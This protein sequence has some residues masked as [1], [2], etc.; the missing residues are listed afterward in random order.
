LVDVRFCIRDLS[1]SQNDTQT[2]KQTDRQTDR[3]T[4]KQTKSDN[5]ITRLAWAEY[6]DI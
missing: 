3:Q 5:Q 4:N 2:D 6:Q 1:C